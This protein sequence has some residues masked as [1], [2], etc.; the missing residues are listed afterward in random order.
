M[1]DEPL[2]PGAGFQIGNL[3]YHQFYLTEFKMEDESNEILFYMKYFCNGSRRTTPIFM[4][5]KLLESLTYEDFVTFIR[6][7]VFESYWQI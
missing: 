7:N 1:P 3:T 2:L 5:S 4:D 6:S